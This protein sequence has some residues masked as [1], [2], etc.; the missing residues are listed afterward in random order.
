M[1]NR[2]KKAPKWQKC[3]ASGHF[4]VKLN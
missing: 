4:E 3:I 1:R 2:L